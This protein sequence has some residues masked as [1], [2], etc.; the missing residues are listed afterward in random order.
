MG[1]E[2]G[3]EGGRGIGGGEVEGGAEGFVEVDID[4]CSFLD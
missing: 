2:E 4:S 3:D 1:E